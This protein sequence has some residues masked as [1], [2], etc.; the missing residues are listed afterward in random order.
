MRHN[1]YIISSGL[2]TKKGCWAERNI[3]AIATNH[4]W[5]APELFED[6]KRLKQMYL[7]GF[8]WRGLCEMRLQ[9]ALGL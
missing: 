8:D 3:K 9:E 7:L 4:K 1:F 6:K 5:R 2:E